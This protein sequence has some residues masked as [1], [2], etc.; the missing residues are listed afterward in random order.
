[1]AVPIRGRI[2]VTPLLASVL[3]VAVMTLDSS[4]S[5]SVRSQTSAAVADSQMSRN[6][7]SD[8]H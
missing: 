6:I 2:L 8:S 5:Q 3:D 7:S 4:L 1:M